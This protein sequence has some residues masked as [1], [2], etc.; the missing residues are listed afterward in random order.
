MTKY[1]EV[2][3]PTLNARDF[4]MG[5]FVYWLMYDI[6]PSFA[7]VTRVFENSLMIK[8]F[9]DG[10]P[11][12]VSKTPKY[13]GVRKASIDETI[14]HFRKISEKFEKEIATRGLIGAI[15]ARKQ[16]YLSGVI[17]NLEKTTDGYY[18]AKIRPADPMTGVYVL[19]GIYSGQGRS[20]HLER[21]E[22]APRLSEDVVSEI[23]II[24]Y[25]NGFGR[26]PSDIYNT[27]ATSHG[28]L[29]AYETFEV[30]VKAFNFV[31]DEKPRRLELKLH[32][33]VRE[34]KAIENGK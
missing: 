24:L 13:G 8:N 23:M 28:S 7:I 11:F 31:F 21:L 10:F 32:E 14:A 2:D 5:D 6:E 34:L 12:E 25:P 20:E 26:I 1:G 22:V 27:P 33:G 19:M 17:S 29:V 18:A 30:P 4:K 15:S 9:D 16:H 3:N